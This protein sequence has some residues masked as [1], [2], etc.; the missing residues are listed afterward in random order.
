M[1]KLLLSCLIDLIDAVF[2]LFE[3][4][5]TFFFSLILLIIAFIVVGCFFIVL[6][7]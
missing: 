1:F 7:S 6:F 5:G 4:I 3:Y 2:M